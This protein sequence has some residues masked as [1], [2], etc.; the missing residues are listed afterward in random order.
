MLIVMI[1]INSGQWGGGRNNENVPRKS[2][3]GMFLGE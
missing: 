3:L 2:D 1:L